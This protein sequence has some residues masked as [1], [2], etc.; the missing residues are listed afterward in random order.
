MRGRALLCRPSSITNR[1]AALKC[2]QQAL[3]ADAG[4]IGARLGI[5]GVLVAN[6]GDGWSQSVHDDM[7]NAERLLLDVLRDD[8]NIPDGR[9]YMGLLRRLQGRLSDS[10]I[11]L[12]TAIGLASN[13]ILANMQLGWTLIHLGRPDAAIRQIE[14]CI[15]LAPRDLLTPWMYG[16]LGL[17]KLLI[18]QID[19]AIFHLRK[20]RA[21]N[22]RLYHPHLYLAAALPLRGEFGEAETA[23]RQAIEVRPEIALPSGFLPVTQVSSQF[24]A[25]FDKMVCA[26]LRQAGLPAVWADTNERL[27]QSPHTQGK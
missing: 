18:G 16:A 25:L 23:L 2:F 27:G 26:G 19:E 3:A 24:V 12:E 11:E 22:P 15:R 20:A 9:G 8:A 7:V 13:N 4:S 17:S 5:S 14:R 10:M 21:I 6:V 1:H